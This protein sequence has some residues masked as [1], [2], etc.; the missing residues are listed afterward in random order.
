MSVKQ[1]APSELIKKHD[2]ALLLV[3]FGS[4]YP[5]PHECFARMRAFFQEQY[6]ERDIFMAF[7]SNMCIRRWFAKSG[8]RYY[9][10]NDWL[11]AIGEAGYKHVSIQSLHIIPGLEYSF[12]HQRY[13]PEFKEKYPNISYAVGEPLLYD[14]EDI[15]AVGDVLYTNF[16]ERLD[17]GEALV[18]MGHG[19][20]TNKFPE[21]N[22]KYM[23][24]HKY[25]QSLDK[26]IAIATVD[27]EEM[28]YEHLE[29][30]LKE[31]CPEVKTINLLPLMSVA[32]DHAL[33]D[34]AGDWEDD[35]ELEEQSWKARFEHAGYTCDR[36]ENCHLHGLADYED[37]CRIWLNHLRRAEAKL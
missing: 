2:E 27:Y 19:N 36:N 22:N 31:T 6:P 32:G 12:I 37:I 10:T 9:P 25:L 28:L 34:M 1:V 17:K 26:K 3:T 24:L 4:T 29:T 15:K 30:Y 33:N 21:A 35:A 13:L 18:L 5:G 23:K 14:E 7:T 20:H 11:N 8:E 16:K